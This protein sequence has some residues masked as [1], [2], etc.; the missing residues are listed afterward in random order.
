[1]GYLLSESGA[2]IWREFNPNLTSITVGNGVTVARYMMIGKTVYFYV[3][4]TLGTTSAVTGD[5]AITLPV[6]KHA[7]FGSPLGLVIFSQTGTNYQML[8]VPCGVV[9]NDGLNLRAVGAASTYEVTFPC[10]S[11]IPFAWASTHY[12]EVTGMYEAA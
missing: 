7:S 8:G 9:G 10:S 2:G 5:F 3:K 12:F 11:I 4:F 6:P 1:M